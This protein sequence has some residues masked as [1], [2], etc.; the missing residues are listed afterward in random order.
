M[1]IP[2]LFR[3]SARFF[4]AAPLALWLL[5]CNSHAQFQI[6]EFLADNSGA[7]LA[8]ED[9]QP[10]DWIEI[11]NVGNAAASIAGYHLS[12]DPTDLGKWTF[13]DESIAPGA[14]LLVFA[15]GKNR[16]LAGSELHTNFSLNAGGED[17]AL[18]TPDG[19]TVVSSFSPE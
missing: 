17:L 8:D 11:Q 4:Y 1:H 16:A 7:L 3:T 13:P 18:V 2:N 12:D 15:S 6:S 5:V 10:S 19:G 9:G 14:Y